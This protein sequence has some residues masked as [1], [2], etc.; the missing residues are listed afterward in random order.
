MQGGRLRFCRQPSP[1]D[2]GRPR[3]TLRA[4]L[5][6]RHQ[7]IIAVDQGESS[8]WSILKNFLTTLDKSPFLDSNESDSGRCG[9]SFRSKADW[10][11]ARGPA[12]ARAEAAHA[13]ARAD[14]IKGL[15]Q[16]IAKPAYRRLLTAEPALRRAVPALIIAFLVTVGVGA[17]IQIYDR[18]H[19][20][21]VDANDELDALA[22]V[23]AERFDRSV[24][25]GRLELSGA[26]QAA[27]EQALPPRAAISER[28]VAATDA[29]GSIIAAHPARGT[30]SRPALQEILARAR[31]QTMASS[32]AGA[33]ETTLA[34]GTSVQ[35]AM[36]PLALP[37]GRLAVVEPR[38]A[39]LA[40]WRAD[41][42]LTITL[43]TTTGFVLLILGFAFHW[44]A[45]RAREADLI[46]DTV[47]CRIDT[48]LN[49]GRCGLWDW[50]LAH[51]RIFWSHSM[52]DIL[53]LPARGDLLTFGEVSALVHPEDAKLYEL[54]AQVADAETTTIDR[55]F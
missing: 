12:M 21:I 42:V 49:R 8:L 11:V 51:G 45:M 48:A 17:I 24:R 29:A 27:L 19:Q 16:A 43:F 55:A 23:V 1:V 44:Q 7:K 26:A 34:D 28:H 52:F 38:A 50:D 10:D 14:S 36:R 40:A 6:P 53:G 25:D 4:G 54:A 32:R 47:R 15:A 41:T 13:S 31:M 46:Y 22:D 2:L 20:A 39:A 3:S 35:T 18:H 30:L 9:T 37:F 33:I 5:R